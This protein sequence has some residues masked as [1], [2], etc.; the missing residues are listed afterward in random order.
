MSITPPA[1]VVGPARAPLPYGLFSVVAPRE[2]TADRWEG[3]GIQFEGLGAPPAAGVIGPFDCEDPTETVGL[4][5]SFDGGLTLSDALPFV[6]YGTYKCTPIGNPLTHA[7]EVARARLATFEEFQVERAFWYGTLGAEALGN[8][9]TLTGATQIDLG[10][11]G[12]VEAIAQIESRLGSTYG[13]L[14]VIHV[15]RGTAV[16]LIREKMLEVKGSRLYTR[17]G[18]PVIAGSGYGEGD[19]YATPAI[20][21]Y[22]SEVF[23]SQQTTGDLLDRA[24]NDLYAVAERAYVI[25]FDDLPI[26]HA[27][28]TPPTV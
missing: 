18:T 8:S 19:I 3:G 4:P 22:R 1:I 11:L 9:P 5:K 27:T 26:L 16:R 21:A 15:G 28:L 7:D 6:V 13:S 14:G 17:L 12:A 20:V 24:Q 10:T 25:G 23:T 2:G